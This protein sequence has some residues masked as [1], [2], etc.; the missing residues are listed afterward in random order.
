MVGA[1]A[2]VIP[3]KRYLW[4]GY[5]GRLGGDDDRFSRTLLLERLPL[6]PR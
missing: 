2:T 1:L 6:L 5:Y 3:L 4:D